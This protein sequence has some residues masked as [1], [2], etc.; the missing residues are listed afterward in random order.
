MRHALRA[1]TAALPVAL[2][3]SLTAAVPPASAA[4]TATGPIAGTAGYYDYS[5][6]AIRD[7]ATGTDTHWWCGDMPGHLIDTIMQEQTRIS[8]GSVVSTQRAVL[9]EGGPGTWDSDLICN[10]SVVRGSFVD[11][12]GDGRT[13]TYAMYYVGTAGGGVGNSIG[14]AFSD[15]GVNWTK[16]PVPVL[17]Y[18]GPSG[19][20][21]YAQPNAVVIGGRV[22][23]LFE[24]DTAAPAWGP[25]PVPTTPAPQ[26]APRPATG[27]S[28]SHWY[29]LANPD[30]V[31]FAGQ[32]AITGKGLPAPEPTW[33]GASYDPSTG[34]WVAAFD[35]DPTRS[36]TTT[37]GVGER[38]QSGVML[39]ATSDLLSGTWTQL[40]TIDTVV[41]G[42]EANFISGLLRDPDG[43]L[44][45]S[46]L[47]SIQVDLS[48]SWPRAPYN[49]YGADLANAG[50][51]NSWQIGA[52]T[53]TPGQPWRT[54]QR[55][56]YSGGHQYAT[57]GWWD[58]SVYH[59]V[60]GNLGKLAE[61]PTGAATVPVWLCKVAPV[62]YV[63]TLRS[64][65]AGTYRA[66]LLGY[67]SPTPGAGLM[68]IYSC[69]I[70]GVGHMVSPDP[71]CEG[72]SADPLEPAGLLGY[73]Q[74]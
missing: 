8:D 6:T 33:G 16:Y 15:D 1:L 17:A 49:A 53:W 19:Y 54:L 66:G 55:V 72:Q 11:P 27:Q 43:A 7:T 34:R 29:T 24:Q 18:T 30:G 64:D 63:D 42:S 23:L 31:T 51:F 50:G 47:P 21:G 46:L 26:P 58:S 57:T 52:A 73:S 36:A 65:C 39:Y 4:T 38:G 45:A 62:D 3:V 25:G 70:P 20:Y 5:D 71:G 44:A 14:A 13:Y 69:V 48:Q 61:A 2:A 10:P 32:A 59:L 60:A 74:T 41:T 67:I 22:W 68:P 56:D 40:D 28:T 9:T 35:V 37:G 12:L